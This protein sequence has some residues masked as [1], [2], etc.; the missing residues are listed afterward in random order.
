MSIVHSPELPIINDRTMIMRTI[1]IVTLWLQRKGHVMKQG[2]QLRKWFCGAAALLLF[3]VLLASCAGGAPADGATP[4]AASGPSGAGSQNAAGGSGSGK[5]GASD[6][7]KAEPSKPAVRSITDYTKRTI[8]IPTA[9]QKIAYIGS[10]PGDLF[11]LGIKPVGASL[12]VIATQIVYPELLG[13]IEDIG[14][15][16]ISLEKLVTLEPDLIL[17]DGVVYNEKSQALDKIAPAVAYDSAAPMYERLRF[18]A[19]ATGKKAEAE[20]WIAGYESKARATLERLKTNPD[21][22]ATVLLQLGKQLYVMGNRGLAVTVFDVLAFKPAPKVKEIIDQ[23]ERFVTVSNEVLPEY[24]G[25]WVFLLSNN[26]ADTVAAKQALLD[27]ALWKAIP[28]VKN[29]KVY[30]FESKWNFDDP[31]TRERLLDELPRLMGK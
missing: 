4:T 14:S 28:A 26:N 8:D 6:A 31:I 20:K 16:E 7:P 2:M 23:S 22:T 17:Y 1:I 30:A 24:V 15:G 25:D 29:G 27:S 9:P 18:I 5:S 19:D 3:A 12:A 11:V 21:D 10:S 13:G